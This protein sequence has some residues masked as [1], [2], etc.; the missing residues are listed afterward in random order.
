METKG[1]DNNEIIFDIVIHYFD[2]W[3]D[4]LKA[5]GR[6]TE[7][8][9]DFMNRT[10]APKDSPITNMFEAFAAGFGYGMELALTADK[11]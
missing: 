4:E 2:K 6:D 5:E 9:N 8:I 11:E 7:L 10:G 3:G 1:T